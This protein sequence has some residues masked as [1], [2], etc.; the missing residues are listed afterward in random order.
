MED[1]TQTENTQIYFSS[2]TISTVIPQITVS[3]LPL[4][5]LI[6]SMIKNGTDI[7]ESYSLSNNLFYAKEILNRER[8]SVIN[9]KENRGYK[10][11]E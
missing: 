10:N 2:S 9:I 7:R 11:S 8:H 3:I 4:K 1:E 6:F 5:I